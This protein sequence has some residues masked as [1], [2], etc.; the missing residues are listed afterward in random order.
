VYK[1]AKWYNNYQ[2]PVVLMIDDLSDA[3]I[4]VYEDT[5]KN[6]WGYLCDTEGSSFS[7][8]KKELLDKFPEIKIT[9]F[10]PY[11]RHN[12]I[13]EKSKFNCKKFDV[14]E[15]EVFT[16]FLKKLNLLGH[17]IAHHGSDHGKYTDEN[18]SS[19]FKNWTHEWALFNSVEEGV[20]VTKKGV[21]VFKKACDI[22]VVGGKYCGYITID[23][24]QKIIDKCDFF[25]WCDKPSYNVG[26]FEESFF[27]ENK[28]ISFPTNF[29]GNSFVRLTYLSGDKNRDK[30]KKILK[31]FQPLYSLYSYW[32]LYKLYK[33]RNIISIQEHN[34][35]S[36][37]A[38]T[39]QSA[40]IVS[41]IKSLN[42]IFKF[43]SK[44]NI[45][46]ANCKDIAKYIYVRD[47]SSLEVVG[48]EIIVNFNNH[49]NLKNC[50]LSIINDTNSKVDNVEIIDG[51]NT[52]KFT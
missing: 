51:I 44:Y 40:N 37:S 38:G 32:Q 19:T 23:N 49:K 11:L 34:S 4:N 24:S 47:N 36:T 35:P 16:H 30:K 42:K 50:V 7:F 52:F 25:Y 33:N 21:E 8:L 15:R 2:A 26:E 41:D 48:N 6:D 28:I 5:Y 39:A 20:R 9:F 27:G 17:E 31:Y 12:V 18:N 3:Y 13:N 43:L 45:W 14:G 29:A 46:H 22:G 1:I 10:T